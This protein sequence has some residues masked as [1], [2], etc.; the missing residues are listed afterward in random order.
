MTADFTGRGWSFPSRISASGGIALDSGGDSVESGIRMILTTTPGERVMRPDFGCA[1]WEHVFGPIDAG[2]LGLMEKA[3]REAL[4]M[5]EPRID[6]IR[7]TGRAEPGEGRVVLEIR[8]SVRAT[9]DE[10]NLIYPFY[11]IPGEEA[12]S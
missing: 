9:N 5:W 11:V 7:V 3:V 2:S 12:V 4:A 6:V 1:L 10:R 8:Y